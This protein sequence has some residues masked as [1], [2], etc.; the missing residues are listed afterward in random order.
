MIKPI[1]KFNINKTFRFSTFLKSQRNAEQ[2]SKVDKPIIAY[3][4]GVFLEPEHSNPLLGICKTFNDLYTSL[5][6][7][8]EE[9][10]TEIDTKKEVK[11]EYKKIEKEKI[12]TKKLTQTTEIKPEVKL[13]EY[14]TTRAIRKKSKIKEFWNDTRFKVSEIAYRTKQIISNLFFYIP[15]KIEDIK[16]EY[17]YKKQEKE[18]KKAYIKEQIAKQEMEVLSN[19]RQ[20]FSHLYNKYLSMFARNDVIPD[21]PEFNHY[22]K[23][24]LVALKALMPVITAC[25]QHQEIINTL[26]QK[27]RKGGDSY[28]NNQDKSD[29]QT[30]WLEEIQLNQIPN[31]KKRRHNFK[32]ELIRIHKIYIENSK[33]VE[34]PISAFNHVTKTFFDNAKN[35]L[36]EIYDIKK[37]WYYRYLEKI[38]KLGLIPR[39]VRVTGQVNLTRCIMKDYREVTNKYAVSGLAPIMKKYSKQSDTIKKFVN[40]YEHYLEK[41]DLAF[42]EQTLQNIENI[43]KQR[44]NAYKK[45]FDLFA[46]GGCN[47]SNICTNIRL[48]EGIGL[49]KKAAVTF[50]SI[51]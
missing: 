28:P 38:P 23:L 48:R 15:N 47:I 41:D 7:K 18:R 19:A 45:L 10:A 50:L 25:I 35:S 11:V 3:M 40:R 32:K 1:S 31:N 33:K 8:V 29:L 44:L 16:L 30:T 46:K 5:S 13:F 4:S 26:K 49:L 27:F 21:V 17:K 24:N 42:V 34:K 20:E 36:Q 39:A 6:E 14:K 12:E 9:A 22:Y 43:K 37:K 51:F 2:I